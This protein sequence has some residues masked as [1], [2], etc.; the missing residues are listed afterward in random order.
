MYC[1]SNSN[2]H[3][4]SLSTKMTDRR[5]LSSSVTQ[6]HHPSN[7][8][9]SPSLIRLKQ[10]NSKSASYV[11]VSS[12]INPVGRW[13]TAC[14]SVRQ[15]CAARL[16][17]DDW[18]SRTAASPATLDSLA[19]G[20]TPVH[21]TYQIRRNQQTIY[22]KMFVMCSEEMHEIIVRIPRGDKIL[23]NT[24]GSSFILRQ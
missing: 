17:R 7:F 13:V 10:F 6:R 15:L 20:S 16:S 23:L 4:L 24:L 8:T 12:N 2:K 11:A 18:W 22:G 21:Y 1:V 14:R 19:R 3:P 9:L 5:S